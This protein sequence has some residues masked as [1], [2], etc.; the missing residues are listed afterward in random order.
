MVD[1]ED[2]GS[3]FD[4][5]DDLGGDESNGNAV[6]TWHLQAFTVVAVVVGRADAGVALLIAHT[7]RPAL[8]TVHARVAVTRIS[9]C[10]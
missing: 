1:T 9:R 4:D 5:D 2:N 3:E 6:R 8:P 10:N 7:A